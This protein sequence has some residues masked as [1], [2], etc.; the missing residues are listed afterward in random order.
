MPLARAPADLERR[1]SR[2]DFDT[3]GDPSTALT[4][5]AFPFSISELLPGAGDGTRNAEK[6]RRRFVAMG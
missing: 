1:C 4:Y 3:C 6:S 2:R 5:A